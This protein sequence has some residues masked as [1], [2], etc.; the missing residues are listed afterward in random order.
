MTGNNR[1]EKET[2]QASQSLTHQLTYNKKQPKIKKL[3]TSRNRFEVLSQTESIEVDTTAFN[4]TSN[5]NDSE[6]NPQQEKTTHL[7]PSIMVKGV[8]DFV[9]LRAELIDLVGSENFT[10]KSSINNLKI[11]TKNPETYRVIIHFLHEEEADFH[12]F[13]MQ[14]HK[15]FRIVIRNLHPTTNTAEI[16]TALEEIGYQVR[17]ITN[18]LH[19]HTKIKLPIFFVDLEPSELNKDIFHVNHLLHTKIKIE[20][21]YKRSD[22]VQCLNCQEYAHTKTYCA[23]TPRCVRCAE[24]HPTSTCQKPRNLPAKCALCQGEHPVNYKGC[25]IHKELQKL[26]NPNSRSKQPTS[27]NNQFN[28]KTTAK[29][30]SRNPTPHLPTIE[31]MQM[32]PQTKNHQNLTATSQTQ[33]FYYLNLSVTSKLS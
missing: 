8:L 21:P 2:T 4:P 20:E 7:P 17:Q 5:I 14:E 29:A 31:H 15:A 26:R 18:V 25:Q 27:I 24:H 32:L 10:F 16:R 9:S 28:P 12:T 1:P 13:Q 11:Q 22:L 19:K 6:S 30:P 3:F 33:V 23:H